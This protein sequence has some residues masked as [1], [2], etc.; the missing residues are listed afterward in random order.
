M[1][2]KIEYNNVSRGIYELFSLSKEVGKEIEHLDEIIEDLGIFWNSDVS[3]EYALKLN[4][5][6]YNV[7]AILKKIVFYIKQL[8]DVIYK[9]DEV[10]G[11]IKNRIDEM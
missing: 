3:E 9:F 8:A 5:D 4:A 1:I 2:I 10:E 11:V 7:R 6:I